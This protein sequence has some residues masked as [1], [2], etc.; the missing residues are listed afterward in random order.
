M[1]SILTFEQPEGQ[2]LMLFYVLK[3]K[4]DKLHKAF[5]DK[6]RGQKKQLSTILI[7]ENHGF[8]NSIVIAELQWLLT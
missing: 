6:G 4:Q 7:L 2:R 8:Q 1:K 5:E 3:V